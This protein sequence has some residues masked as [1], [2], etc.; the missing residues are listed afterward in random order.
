MNQEERRKEKLMQILTELR[1]AQDYT[2]RALNHNSRL[3]EII[4]EEKKEKS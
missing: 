1:V 4:A 2:M 3:R